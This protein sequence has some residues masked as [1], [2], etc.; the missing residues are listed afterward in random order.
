MIKMNNICNYIG[1]K[2]IINKLNINQNMNII[3]GSSSPRR[4]ELLKEITEDFEIIKPV[5]DEN[6]ILKKS[7]EKNK[8]LEFLE[9][10]FLSCSNIAYEKA[11]SIFEKNK[12]S[13]I[14]SA[15]TVVVTENRILG[16]PKNKDDAYK[17]L[18]SLLGD[19]HYVTTGVCI[20]I[21]E[22]NYD[23]FYSVTAVKFI[24]E[25]KFVL[26]YLKDYVKSNEPMDK[27]GSYGIQQIGSTV[28]ELILGDYYNI[29]G[30]PIVEIQRRLYENFS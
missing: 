17:T 26:K 25:N 23:L 12:D 27:A 21:D 14:I 28:V 18:T 30:F 24:N 15:D 7:F 4:I 10:A 8:N 3:L 29:V 22:N 1:V 5:I 16:K 2:N 19:Y 20:F 6:Y 13:I 9:D 11:K